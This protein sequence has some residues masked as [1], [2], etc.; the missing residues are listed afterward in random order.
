[1]AGEAESLFY[2]NMG[3]GPLSCV[4]VAAHAERISRLFKDGGVG[5]RVGFVAGQAFSRPCGGVLALAL[6]QFPMAREAKLIGGE[7]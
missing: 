4:F 7:D 1:M 6:D 5:T 3:K 2:R